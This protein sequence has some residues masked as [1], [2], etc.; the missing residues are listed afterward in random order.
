IRDATVT[1]VQTCALPISSGSP[2]IGRQT[3]RAVVAEKYARSAFLSRRPPPSL[4]PR[5]SN[6]PAA[7]RGPARLPQKSR[8]PLSAAHSRPHLART[9]T[10]GPFAPRSEG[11]PHPSRAVPRGRSRQGLPQKDRSLQ[12]WP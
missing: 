2:P 5:R 1:G 12:F 10:S 3:A 11:L 8:L 6:L 7:A 9:V 4:L